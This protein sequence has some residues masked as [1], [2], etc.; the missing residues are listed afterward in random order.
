MC[1]LAAYTCHGGWYENG[2]SFVVTTPLTRDSTAARRYCFVARGERRAALTLARSA[3]NCE[4]A[5][6]APGLLFHATATGNRDHAYL[7]LIPLV[8]FLRKDV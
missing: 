8:L 2:T 6:P 5:L 3:A 4:R 7:F 1:S